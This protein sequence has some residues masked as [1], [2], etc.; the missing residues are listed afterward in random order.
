MCSVLT[1]MNDICTLGDSP[2]DPVAKTLFPMQGPGLDPWSRNYR[3]N[4]PQLISPMSQG[5]NLPAT[6]KIED[7]VCYN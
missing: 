1:M 6:T 2:G 7:L 5:K 3:Y 4:M